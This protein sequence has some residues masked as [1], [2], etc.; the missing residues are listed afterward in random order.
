[1]AQTDS[2]GNL[3]SLLYLPLKNI[4]KPDAEMFKEKM[5]RGVDNMMKTYS[6]QMEKQRE[7]LAIMRMIEEM[8]AQKKSDTKKKSARKRGTRQR[9]SR[10]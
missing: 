8:T 7:S 9:R 1:M 5:R 2:S 3:K 4:T 6:K 10:K